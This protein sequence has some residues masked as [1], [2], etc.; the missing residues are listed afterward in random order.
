MKFELTPDEFG[1][2]CVMALMR[3][4]AASKITNKQDEWK[5]IAGQLRTKIPTI[6]RY[7]TMFTDLSLASASLRSIDKSYLSPVNSN[8]AFES[9]IVYVII[10]YQQAHNGSTKA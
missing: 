8:N 6:R 7:A 1:H 3:M 4:Q 5:W 2:S 10:F 9:D